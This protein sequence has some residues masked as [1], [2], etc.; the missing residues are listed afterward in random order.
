MTGG[1]VHDS[2]PLS[3]GNIIF[4]DVKVIL[5]LARNWLF[6]NQGIVSLFGAAAD[7]KKYHRQPKPF[8]FKLPEHCPYRSLRLRK[9]GG[10]V[11]D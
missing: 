4:A 9:A 2:L 7:A 8:H 6:H 1:S 3:L 5:P 10:M 11:Y